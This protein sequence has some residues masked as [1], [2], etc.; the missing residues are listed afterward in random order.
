M[1][2]KNNYLR[3][4]ISFI[5]AVL[6]IGIAFWGLKQFQQPQTSLDPKTQ[7][8]QT[9]GSNSSPTP[10]QS[11]KKATTKSIQSRISRG[12]KILIDTEEINV[13]FSEFQ[14]AKKRG[15]EAMAAG[16]YDEAVVHFERAIKRYPNAP[17]TLI[18]LNNARIGNK[19]AYTIAV[20]IPISSD[21]SGAQAILRGVAQAQ[22]EV[23]LGFGIG[24]VPLK[25]VIANDDDNPEIAKQI[26]SEFVSDSSILGVIGHYSS[27]TT[28]AAGEVY[29]GGKLVSIS[30]SST[31]IA[32]SGKYDWVFRTVPSDAFGARALA[33]YMLDVLRRKKAVIFYNPESAYSQSL[34]SE[35]V[36]A[37]SLGGGQ[38]V[39]E[40][41]LSES[42]FSAFK[43]IKKAK[44]R[45]AEVLMLAP[46]PAFLDKALQ[47]VN[48][49]DGE[50]DLLG[51]DA[52]YAL[53]TLELGGKDA[54]NLTVAVVWH[55]DGDPYSD[56]PRRSK[57]LW[58]AEVNWLSAMAYDA[59]QA[60][61]TALDRSPT[62]PGIQQT[63]LA[64]DFSAFGASG[65][66]LFQQTGDRNG[67]IQL[68]KV[69]PGSKS[70]AG[71][72]FVPIRW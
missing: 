32:L 27:G 22:N 47:V 56:F 12:E 68:V 5:L 26:A 45:G 53:K 72:D 58:K 15:V 19:K 43:S 4:I 51:G 71:Y 65:E 25:V 10:P 41:S 67:S 23:N 17:E 35:F 49:N 57:Q 36:T 28:L 2:K 18:Y 62:R 11:Q 64:S 31:S 44:E 40:I 13:R 63:L 70:G 38:V 50:L 33:N 29:N 8:P 24:G 39:D 1:Q 52:V 37:V 55:I 61:I 7:E 30:P 66:I 69:A 20:S 14:D 46:T 59:A 9:S 3:E 6:V 60:F 21:V 16:N 34:K 42:N 48:V 54:R